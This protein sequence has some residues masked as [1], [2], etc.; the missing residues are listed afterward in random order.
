MSKDKIMNIEKVTKH[1]DN[2]ISISFSDGAG[3]FSSL[4]VFPS[5]IIEN[6]NKIKLIKE[7]L[8]A[9]EVSFG[10]RTDMINKIING[11]NNATVA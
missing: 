5:E 6:H 9:P 10:G 4:I 1:K 2:T 3:I 8:D 11:E 7:V